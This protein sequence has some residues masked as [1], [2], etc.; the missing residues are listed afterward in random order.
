MTASL[1]VA[2]I[3]LL[4][5]TVALVLSVRMRQRLGE[6]QAELG[7]A[8]ADLERERSAT[9]AAITAAHRTTVAEVTSLIENLLAKVDTDIAATVA[10]ALELRDHDPNR[11]GGV[12]QSRS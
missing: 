7:S 3:A 12:D 9:A 2:G 8:H 5:A 6:T 1:I 4:A 10:E 11:S